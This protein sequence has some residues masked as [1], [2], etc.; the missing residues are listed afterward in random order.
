[1]T[2]FKNSPR[3]Q[4]LTDLANRL[5]VEQTLLAIEVPLKR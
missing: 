1:M 5:V 2:D 3:D 4:E